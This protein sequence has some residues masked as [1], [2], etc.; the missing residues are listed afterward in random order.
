MFE[1]IQEPLAGLKLLKPRIFSD[2]RG[3]FVKTY[4]ENL[5]HGLGIDFAL[6]EEFFSISNKNVLRGMHFQTPPHAHNKL[7]YCVAGSVL[8][9]VV[10]IRKDKPTFGQSVSFELSAANRHLLYIPVGFAHGFLALSD[11]ACMVYKTDAAY[12]PEND[13]GIHWNS[14]GYQWP[15]EEPIISERDAAF[16]KLEN[17]QSPF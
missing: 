10:D 5:Y 13:T 3:A 8:D 1:L 11:D 16:D 14:F 6:R 12:A 15:V 9:V 7:V 2:P 17:F 4:H